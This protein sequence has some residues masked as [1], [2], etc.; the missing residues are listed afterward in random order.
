MSGFVAL[1]LRPIRNQPLRA[2]LSMSGVAVGIALMIAMLGL[3]GSMTSAADRLTNLAGGADIE[4]SAPND[5]GLPATLL[6]EVAAVPG[7]KVAAP[8][9]R[10]N[11]ILGR[12]P[13]L[14]LGL[15]ERLT[16]IGGGGIDL[17]ACLPSTLRAGE[18]VLVG[19]GLADSRTAQLVTPAND[20]KVNVLGRISCSAA[21][22]INTGRFVAAPL[23]LAEQLGGRPG[24]PDA[25]EIKAAPGVRHADLTAAIDQ[26]VAGRGVV[27]TPK[28]L[29]AQARKGTAAFKQGTSVMVGL[30]LVVGAF[31]VFN[32]VSMTA[33]ERR[34]ELATLRAI[35]GHRRR[36][37]RDFLLEMTMLGVVGSALGVFLGALA[38]KRLIARIPPILVDTVGVQ[39][40]FVLGRG[41]IA[42][43]LLIG[44]LVTVGAALFPARHA[45]TVEP[46]EAMRSEG[47]SESAPPRHQT[48]V[49]ILV[50]GL[51]LFVG[52]SVLAVSGTSNAATLIGFTT[53]TL[54]SLV[55]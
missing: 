54:G 22:T 25:I 47:P 33:L 43:A 42:A 16:Q 51:T 35:G 6:D 15:D 39:P 12:A 30:S 11:V 13:V 46:V 4:V 14:L 52:G 20:T 44:T 18:G 26:V 21:R 53:I 48:N 19:P 41:M 37:L 28:L 3:F 32:T 31:C 55:S 2:I 29:A 40:S 10:T 50:I 34:R 36:L 45:V 17:G 7:V 49:V 1:H 23:A 5:S 38:G 27:A 9:V 24:R 8:L